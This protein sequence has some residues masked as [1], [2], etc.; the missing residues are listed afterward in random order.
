[1][2]NKDKNNSSLIKIILRSSFFI[3]HFF[4]FLPH[5][6][7]KYPPKNEKITAIV[8]ILVY[9]SCHERRTY[10]PTTG[11]AESPA[12]YAPQDIRYPADGTQSLGQNSIYNHTEPLRF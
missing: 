7:N 12:V 2:G 6:G 8:R 5:I 1:L 10:H 3:L 11:V 4:V 9:G